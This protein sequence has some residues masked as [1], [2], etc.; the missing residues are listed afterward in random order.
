MASKQWKLSDFIANRNGL[1]CD[2]ALLDSPI[3]EPL[4]T[5]LYSC[6]NCKGGKIKL[7]TSWHLGTHDQSIW[8]YLTLVCQQPWPWMDPEL[9]AWSET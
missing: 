3:V 2:S 6:I 8:W 1:H 4:G 5:N 9:N 7:P